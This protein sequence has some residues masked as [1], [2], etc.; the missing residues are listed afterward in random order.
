M[1]LSIPAIGAA[2]GLGAFEIWRA[3]GPVLWID[4][5]ITAA[6]SFLVALVAIAG[7]LRWLRRSTYTPFVIY[8]VILGA[9]LLAWAYGLI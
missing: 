6:I 3:G 5:A 2:A 9:V 8:R 4:A 1:L 7:L